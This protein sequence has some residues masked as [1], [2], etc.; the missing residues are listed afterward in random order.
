MPCFTNLNFTTKSAA[1]SNK[2]NP[3][4]ANQLSVLPGLIHQIIKEQ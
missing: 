1:S 2:L 4:T 3:V